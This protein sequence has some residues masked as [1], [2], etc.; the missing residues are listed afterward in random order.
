MQR[1]ALREIY[2]DHFVSCH[3]EGELTLGRC[4]LDTQSAFGEARDKPAKLTICYRPEI[5]IP[6]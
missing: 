3:F 2:P 4:H 5:S 6:L 1:P